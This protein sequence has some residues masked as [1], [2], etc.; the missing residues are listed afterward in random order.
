MSTRTLI[1]Q[2]IGDIQAE[3]AGWE[4]DWQFME[5]TNIVDGLAKALEI[6]NMRMKEEN[7][8]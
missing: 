3:I 6:I 5:D 1:E 2:I 8:S 7:A 4:S